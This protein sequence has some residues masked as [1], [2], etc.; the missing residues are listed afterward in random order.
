MT[1]VPVTW[2]G[3]T[4]GTRRERRLQRRSFLLCRVL[5]KKNELRLHICHCQ[6]GSCWFTFTKP[7]LK[8]ARGLV[9]YR[10]RSTTDQSKPRCL[11]AW[12]SRLLLMERVPPISMGLTPASLYLCR[13]MSEFMSWCWANALQPGGWCLHVQASDDHMSPGKWRTSCTTNVASFPWITYR[14]Y[15]LIMI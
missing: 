13:F 4:G 1:L 14:L 10:Q 3:A 8:S 9:A 15:E 7:W 12:R 11:L 6:T 2:R 5:K